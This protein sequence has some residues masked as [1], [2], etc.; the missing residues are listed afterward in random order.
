MVFML[1]AGTVAVPQIM[2]S[3]PGGT[4][5]RWFT[6]VIYSW[7]FDGGDWNHGAAYAFAL[8]LLCIVFI[9][10]ML[11]LFKVSLGEIAK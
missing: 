11:R 5:A 6:Q 1:S 3:L 4:N 10:L 2:Q 9:V 7:F 8:L